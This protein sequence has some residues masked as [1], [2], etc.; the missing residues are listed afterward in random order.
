MSADMCF[1][2]LTAPLTTHG[3]WCPDC[4]MQVD[5]VPA[6][7]V[8][9]STVRRTAEQR[10]E[11]ARCDELTVRVY[12]DDRLDLNPTAEELRTVCALLSTVE[13][14]PYHPQAVRDAARRLAYPR[15][16]SVK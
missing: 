16:E 14:I 12:L 8:E 13:A 6:E 15:L 10:E 4:R 1:R 9:R 3:L 2:C 11:N 5:A 7:P